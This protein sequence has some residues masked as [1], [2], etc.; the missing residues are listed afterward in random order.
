[1]IYTPRPHQQ[2]ASEF[3]RTHKR[4]ALFLDMGLGKTVVALTRAKELLDDFA[5][6][7]VLVIAPKRVAED[8]WSRE[9]EKWDHLSS[10]RVVKIMGPEAKRLDALHTPADIYVINRE[11]VVWLVETLGKN[12]C[13]GMVIIDELSSF[14]NSGSKRW[15]ALKKVIR[16]SDYV[17]GLTGTPASNGYLDLW[18]EMFL[19]DNGDTLGTTKGNYIANYFQPGRRSGNIIYEYRIRPGAKSTIDK[20]LKRN[21]L[22]MSKEDWLKLPPLINN[23]VTVRMSEKERSIYDKLKKESVLP[24][25][26]GEIAN[27]D[28]M[29]SAVVGSTAAVLSNK[30]LQLANGAV[31]D[32]AGAV[33]KI[34]DRKLDALEEIVEAAEGQSILVFYIYK[35]DMER[36]R[37][38]FPTAV[39]IG[40][41]SIDAWNKGE[42]PMLLCHPASA[43]HGL[44]LQAG[45]H[46]AVWFGVPWS[47]ELYQQAAARLYRMGQTE[48]VIQHHIICEGTL[49][50]KVMSALSDKDNTQRGL[51]DALK[52]Y[53]A[54]KR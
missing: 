26:D 46:I 40:E 17:L 45:G 27:L 7:K 6:N 53:M 15:R 48:S 1:M 33:I 43:G 3:C 4:C 42:I 5:V 2:I 34:H 50:E 11:M 9:Q 20:K 24:L 54:E 39:P 29:D 41:G 37:A 28:N 25:L 49:D 51:L 8:T 38:R 22:S 35:H 14:K 36:I 16:M 52:M 32:D 30:L 21:C 44:N 47:L 23:T 10:L 13:F 19:I 18:A 31:Y 12:W